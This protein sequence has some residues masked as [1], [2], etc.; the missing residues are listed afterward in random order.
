[1]RHVVQPGQTL[2]RIARVYGVPMDELARANGIDDP[3]TI[4]V[5]SSLRIPGASRVLDVP[6]YP[7]PLPGEAPR[8]QLAAAGWI[9]PV[10]GGQVLSG[11]GV[12]R[13]THHHTG[14]DID[15]R[16]GQPVVAAREGRVVYSGASMRGYGK[17][18]ILDH[19]DG[20]SSLYAHNG[21]LL[22]REGERVNGGDRIA[23]VGRSGNATTE[24]CHFEIRRGDVPIDPLDYVSPGDGAGTP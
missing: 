14:V 24:H 17:T 8:S 21:A 15:G 18:V 6:P 7:A 4:A 13:R 23:R 2:W 22:V 10:D 1:V 11:F 19:G 3:S 12:P 9:W 16:T 5:G 20:L